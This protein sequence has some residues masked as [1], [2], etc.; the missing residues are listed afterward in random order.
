MNAASADM[1]PAPNIGY[2]QRRFDEFR[3]VGG[4]MEGGFDTVLS[5]FFFDRRNTAWETTG[6]T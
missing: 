3:P 1:Y 2:F 4:K 5:P 6:G